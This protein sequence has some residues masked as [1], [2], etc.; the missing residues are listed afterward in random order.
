MHVQAVWSDHKKTV[1]VFF[2]SLSNT[3]RACS[4]LPVMS[5]VTT[6]H[7][8]RPTSSRQRLATPITEVKQLAT[9]VTSLPSND[10]RDVLRQVWHPLLL[11]ATRSGLHSMNHSSWR[12]S[13]C[14][15]IL[16]SFCLKLFMDRKSLQYRIPATDGRLHWTTKN[17]SLYKRLICGCRKWKR[18]G[19][20]VV[21]T[22]LLTREKGRD[23][24]RLRELGLRLLIFA[25]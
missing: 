13:R 12:S 22:F 10:K 16:L 18:G 24:F 9:P 20:V 21:H 5:C 6:E 17:D 3:R 2:P 25:K 11:L 4:S 1:T 8:P 15:A 7:L 14:T 23:V 19:K